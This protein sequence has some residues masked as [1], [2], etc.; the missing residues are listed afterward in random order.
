MADMRKLTWTIDV[1]S[2]GAKS[3]I[4]TFDKAM[5]GVKSKMEGADRK[6]S[7]FGRGANSTFSTITNKTKSLGS[8]IGQ[9]GKRLTEAGKDVKDFGKKWMKATAPL[10]AIGG[11]GFKMNMDV[12]TASRKVSTLT[13][14]PLQNIRS[15]IKGISTDVG[16]KQ[17]EIAEAAYMALS[18]GIDEKD[19]WQFTKSSVNLKKA[20]FTDL[21]TA[22]DATTS[23]LN[24]YNLEAKEA[25]KIQDIFVKTQD[26]GKITVDQLGAN[27]GRVIPSA[28]ALGVG[29][30]DVGASLAILT[31]KGQTANRATTYLDAMFR[32]FNQTGSKADKT[33]KQIAGKGF[34]ELKAEGFRLHDVLGMLNDEAERQNVGL[35]DFFG[36]ATAGSAAYSL[37]ADGAE[38][39]TET[40]DK[41]KN[42]EGS[43]QK[44]VDALMGPQERLNQSMVKMQNALIDVGGALSPFISDLAE[45]ISGAVSKF[46][47]LDEGTQSTIVQ[48]GA[49]LVAVGPLSAG[50][51]SLMGVAGNVVGVF[52]RFLGILSPL[53]GLMGSGLV[54]AIGLI[55]SPMGLLIGLIGGAIAIGVNLYNNWEQV[56][57]K[58]QELGGGIKGY[59]LAS[60]QVTIQGF[61]NLKNTAVGAL[62][63]IRAKW[64][65]VKNFLKNPIKGVVSI[66]Q[67]VMGGGKKSKKG[68]VGGSFATGL[69]YVPKDN[70]K[71]NLHEGEMVLTKK[72]SEE[73]R[74]L[75]GTKDRIPNINNY[76]PVSS[77]ERRENIGN[78]SPSIVINVSSEDKSVAQ[79]IKDE[80][81]AVLEEFYWNLDLQRG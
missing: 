41:V 81:K 40:L 18:S 53:V 26:L 70:F 24:A 15:Q 51:G 77:Y 54:G 67:N 76:P 35:A 19:V 37:I 20:G 11:A 31:K 23:V 72:T 7:A 6:T 33:L 2:M 29:I 9:I 79:D 71:A 1:N 45:A 64:E 14:E 58:A 10:M 22:I 13:S 32:E 34:R 50:L 68:S 30:D 80:V 55:F 74:K 56:R 63:G 16:I 60:I 75:G 21:E 42:S 3:S 8:S 25:S 27:I 47:E 5:D 46:S 49:L 43:V 78:Y 52:G 57:Q 73:Y 4:K 38:A 36:A 39:Y 28:S 65:S 66:A 62:E 44:N 69:D 61:I 48:W 12:D 59:L 17:T